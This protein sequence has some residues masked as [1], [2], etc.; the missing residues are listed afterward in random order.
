MQ[1]V[2]RERAP[3]HRCPVTS[4][5]DPAVLRLWDP[6]PQ[7]KAALALA[8]L[9]LGSRRSETGLFEVGFAELARAGADMRLIS[10]DAG[11]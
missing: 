6:T 7:A 2:R 3:A 9:V 10:H 5:W 4:I 11:R 1:W 8:S